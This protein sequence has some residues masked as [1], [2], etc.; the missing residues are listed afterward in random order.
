MMGFSGT[1]RVSGRRALALRRFKEEVV[2][3][4]VVHSPPTP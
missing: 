4:H 3:A 2:L 1:E